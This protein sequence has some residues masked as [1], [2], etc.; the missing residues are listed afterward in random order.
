MNHIGKISLFEEA[1]LFDLVCF[2]P[3]AREKKIQNHLKVVKKK[4]YQPCKNEGANRFSAKNQ[5]NELEGM[6]ETV[7]PGGL[8]VNF[9]R[10]RKTALILSRPFI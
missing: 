8:G 1:I 4:A 9:K 10:Q 3:N 5:R 2:A 7:R 6:C